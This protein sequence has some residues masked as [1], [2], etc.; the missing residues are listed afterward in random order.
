MFTV[1]SGGKDT[2]VADLPTLAAKVKAGEV[3]PD[4][5]VYDHA[6]GEW[7]T[8][9]TITAPPKIAS[10][11]VP[12]VQATP[13]TA[14]AG[15]V[16]TAQPGAAAP[17]EV[18]ID[19]FGVVKCPGCGKSLKVHTSGV[20]HCVHCK[21]RFR[22]VPSTV[23]AP[24]TMPSEVVP[25]VQ[26]TTP[27][28]PPMP[29]ATVQAA[30]AIAPPDVFIDA[31]GVVKCPGCARSLKVETSGVFDCV[32]CKSRFHAVRSTVT[33]PREARN[34]FPVLVSWVLCGI[35]LLIAADMVPDAMALLVALVAAVFCPPVVTVVGKKYPM[36][37]SW[38]ARVAVAVVLL[39][40][41]AALSGSARPRNQ[42]SG[43]EAAPGVASVA[44]VKEA[45]S[46]DTWK[47]SQSGLT[48]QA[49]PPSVKLDRDG[50]QT[51]CKNL[52]LGGHTDWRIPSISELRTLVRG[53]PATQTGG[54]CNV[55]DHCLNQRSFDAITG[56]ADSAC[57]GCPRSGGPAAGGCYWPAQLGGPSDIVYW[58]SS[59]VADFGLSVWTVQ[60]ADGSVGRIDGGYE[61]RALEPSLY[62]RCVR[63]TLPARPALAGKT[64]KNLP[65]L[66]PWNTRLS[67]IDNDA[68]YECNKKYEASLKK[69]VTSCVQPKNK[70]KATADNMTEDF[71]YGGIKWFDLTYTFFDD[72]L[73]FVM[74]K[75]PS[76]GMVSFEGQKLVERTLTSGETEIF[77]ALLAGADV[78]HL[79][80]N[81]GPPLRNRHFQNPLVYESNIKAIAEFK[82]MSMGEAKRQLDQVID[83]LKCI[84]EIGRFTDDEEKTFVAFLVNALGRPE[85]TSGTTR[86]KDGRMVDGGI[87]YRW[88]D[89]DINCDCQK[90]RCGEAIAFIPVVGILSFW[91][92]C[93]EGN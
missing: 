31:F 32:H 88:G 91:R 87:Y 70:G 78:L 63:G 36:I 20:F 73:E 86:E 59:Q 82:G 66:L 80:G 84:N 37:A 55:T 39:V 93:P 33:A 13:P 67:E 65:G 25:P 12:P 69:T 3:A 19:A 34:V 77:K 58:S 8:A 62:T 60:F 51:Y 74:L 6:Q 22:A 75:K 45:P 52:N 85:M 23:T 79:I 81:A 90:S 28:S 21:S 40:I 15:P 9:A 68:S 76:C 14:P 83:K 89:M 10:G 72:V 26:T 38:R 29:M 27:T 2:P 56:C 43:Q 11:A 57:D 50:A 4:A 46:G 49:T 18:F 30:H 16:A 17:P 42:Q 47:D 54:P 1:R 7:K 5:A 71:I 35:F 44:N 64:L 48:W 61:D 41:A 53:C 92:G 24:S